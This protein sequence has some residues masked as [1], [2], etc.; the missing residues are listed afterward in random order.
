MKRSPVRDIAGMVES[1]Y[2]ASRVA[3][4]REVES[5]VIRAENLLLMEQWAQFL[6]YWASV[7]FL[8]KYLATAAGEAFL[9][10]TQP[11]LQVLLDAYLLEK[12]VYELG[13]ELDN[14]PEMAEIPLQRIL[15]LLGIGKN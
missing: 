14:R 4:R 13:Y 6:Y 2:Y 10:K 5:G 3:L 8:K 12:A 7:A 9:P 11:E 1:F 15:E